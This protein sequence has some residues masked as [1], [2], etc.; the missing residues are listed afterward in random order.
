SDAAWGACLEGKSTSA[1]YM[2][3]RD[4]ARRADGAYE[5]RDDRLRS[6]ARNLDPAGP[7]ADPAGARPRRALARG[8]G[9]V[10]ALRTGLADVRG[11]PCGGRAPRR[12]ARLVGPGVAARN[13]ARH[14][15]PVVAVAGLLAPGRP[16]GAVARRSGQ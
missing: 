6:R 1:V 8:H 12:Q 9:A 2:L 4:G 3:A 5:P 15:H 16:A 14:R 7:L 10:P 11:R 13:R